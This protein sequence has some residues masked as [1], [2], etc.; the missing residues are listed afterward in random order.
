MIEIPTQLRDQCPSCGFHFVHL[1][2]F[3]DLALEKL[4]GSYKLFQQLRAKLYGVKKPRSVAQLN[5]YWSAA[6]F[7]AG[8]VSDHQNQF[9]KE[10]ID[11]QVKVK[12]AKKKPAL[13]KRYIFQNN[14]MHIAYISISFENLS[15]L[16]ACRF[17]DVA[18]KE[19]ADMVG[20][21]VEEFIEVVKINM[22]GNQ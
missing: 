9:D 1:I 19:L 13:I 22:K 3:G 10:D 2:P 15:H 20:M 17:F 18:F 12:V 14:I 7:V 16:E 4:K 11:F 6:G 21:E 8:Q 5:T